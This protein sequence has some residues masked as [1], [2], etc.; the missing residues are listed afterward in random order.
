MSIIRLTTVRLQQSMDRNW[1]G[2]NKHST[3]GTSGWVAIHAHQ[4]GSVRVSSYI[5]VSGTHHKPQAHPQHILPAGARSAITIAQP[6]TLPLATK[7]ATTL[8]IHH[9]T[10]LASLAE[11]LAAYLAAYLLAWHTTLST[12]LAGHS[13]HLLR[14][15]LVLPYSRARQLDM[16]DNYYLYENYERNGKEGGGG[17]L[18]YKLTF[19]KWIYCY[20]I[21]Y[22]NK[23]AIPPRTP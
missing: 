9:T 3:A 8:A 21:S 16:Y 6:A 11:A 2:G 5:Y 15:L 22:N 17:V 19:P 4:G 23:G 1:L 13:Q 10:L 14:C 18:C 12:P 20:D 7:L